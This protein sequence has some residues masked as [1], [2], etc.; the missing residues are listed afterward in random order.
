[1]NNA[2]LV[3]TFALLPKCVLVI[4]LVFQAHLASVLILQLLLRVQT[5]LQFCQPAVELQ[6]Q[7][8]A[9]GFCLASERLPR[10]ETSVCDQW[11]AG[12]RKRGERGTWR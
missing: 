1:M 10:Q 12:R 2:P 8:Q 3:F 5:Q 4:L 7:A 11:R 6:V 9:T